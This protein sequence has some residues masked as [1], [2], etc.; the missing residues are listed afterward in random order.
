MTGMF[1][2]RLLSKS[3]SLGVICNG[4]LA[5]LVAVTAG[6]AMIEPWAA[7]VTGVLG[8][9]AYYWFS[10]LLVR[11]R[12]DDPV[13]ASP[14][15]LTAG[16]VGVVLVGLF[17]SHKETVAAYGAAPHY[18]AFMGGGGEQVRIHSHL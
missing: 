6:C 10:K 16:M 2:S 7:F 13:D 9:S 4:V 11:L 3:W 5:G 17:A 1:W 18:G 12:I 14:L 15:H 8:A